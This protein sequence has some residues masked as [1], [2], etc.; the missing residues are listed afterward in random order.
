MADDES[1]WEEA[2]DELWPPPGDYC[3]PEE[4]LAPPQEPADIAEACAALCSDEDLATCLRVLTGLAG[5]EEVFLRSRRFREVR[6]SVVGLGKTMTT[7]MYGGKSANEYIEFSVRNHIDKAAKDRLR[8][9]DEDKVKK[10]K[11]R[12]ARLERLAELQG[13]QAEGGQLAL[14]GVPDG[15]VVTDG[16]GTGGVSV[17]MLSAGVGARSSFAVKAGRRTLAAGEG[18][19]QE[20]QPAVEGDGGQGSE[21]NAVAEEE[22]GGWQLL[23]QERRCYQCKGWVKKLHH[24]YA[25]LC[26]DCSTLNW[27]KRH[28]AAE[29]TGR[30]AL[31]TGGRVKIGYHVALKLLRSGATTIV[32]SRCPCRLPTLRQSA[33][34]LSPSALKAAAQVRGGVSR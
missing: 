23:Q 32:T 18:L 13:E 20:G 30:V 5:Q 34:T 8:R 6:S 24:F 14:S 22:D 7:K 19:D 28:Q 11:L 4:E 15:A 25:Q 31:V 12:A 29:L 27:E 9:R 26:P 33:D 17:A 16:T 10:T 2:D 1:C 21:D 3:E